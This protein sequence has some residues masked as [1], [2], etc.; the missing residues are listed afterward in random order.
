MIFR[1]ML[2]ALLLRNYRYG[3]ILLDCDFKKPKAEIRQINK[4]E[5][6]KKQL[7]TE[8]WWKFIYNVCV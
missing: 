1:I 3:D 8:K 7:E 6:N 2:F 5:P 4:D